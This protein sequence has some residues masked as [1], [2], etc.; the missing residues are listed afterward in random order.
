MNFCQTRDLV[1]D[2][3]LG[4][5]PGF[6][7][8]EGPEPLLVKIDGGDGASVGELPDNGTTQAR[9]AANASS[10]VSLYFH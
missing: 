1:V 6:D 9:K 3:E 8:N 10:E 2:V 4:Q 5:G 7:R